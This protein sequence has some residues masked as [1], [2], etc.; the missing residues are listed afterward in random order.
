MQ[1]HSAGPRQRIM[2][3]ESTR[4]LCSRL[5]LAASLLA[6][7]AP[8]APAQAPA[9]AP[10]RAQALEAMRRATT[11]MVEKVSTN[12]GYVW[13]YLPDVSRRWGEME[14]R[15]SMVWV[16]P[17]GTPTMGHLFLDAYHATGDE[18]YYRAAER[19]A[20]AL[21]AG[22]HPSGGW[23]YVIDTAGEPSLQE[24]YD[25][26]GR[27]GWRLEEFQHN[28]R[29]GTFDDG[30]TSQSATLL[31]RLYLEKRD[32]SI[33]AALDKAIRFV[34]DSQYPM[35]GWPQRFPLRNEFTHH[36]KPDYTS[37]ITINDDVAAGNI[38]FLTLCYQALGD[39]A[40][41]GPI[42]RGMDAFVTL[43]Q[44]PPQAGWALQYT[45]DLKPSGARTYE[46]T[47]LV[48][49][50]TGA[51][52]EQLLKF[53]ELTGDAK[54]LA[55]IP[56]ALAWLESVKLPPDV[57]AIAG[58]GRTHP[59]FVEV[60][61][62]KPLYVHRRGSNV[63]NGEYYVDGDPHNTIGHYSSFR[64]VDV[65]GLRKRYEQ[66][67]ATP[68]NVASKGSPLGAPTR[69]LPRFFEAAGNRPGRPEPREPLEVRLS[70]IVSSLDERG[71]WIAD[72]ASTSHPYKG[73]GPKTVAPGD[74]ARTSVGDDSDTSPYRAEGLKG[75]STSLYMRNMAELIRFVTR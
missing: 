65:A 19:A 44:P 31:L 59:T 50:T 24:W 13:A 54:Y 74:F 32:P 52:I 6:G 48:T 7:A 64:L 26:V 49:H 41:L 10:T 61:T 40:L 51:A 55:R 3:R 28:W 23:N 30:G 43:Q 12:G 34:L 29:N 21:V 33:K 37:F 72:L 60:G 45:T 17:P 38:E 63:V 66:A 71:R 20:R 46:P 53:Y 56:E 1:E 18:Y 9:S 57:A 22:Q 69:T 39:T 47:A 75:I 36:G 70:R 25:T 8:L 73:D 4:S 27:N 62:N 14:A 16:Q 15:A 5:L 42:R 68:P 58:G 11:F 2:A 67:K 35:G